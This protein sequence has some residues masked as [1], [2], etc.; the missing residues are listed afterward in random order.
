MCMFFSLKYTKVS[1]HTTINT[2]VYYVSMY[3]YVET[4]YHTGSNLQN[5]PLQLF[6]VSEKSLRFIFQT[7]SQNFRS[8]EFKRIE[9]GKQ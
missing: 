8:L 4:M 6:I 9:L 2:H 7:Y 3:T 1:T 5:S